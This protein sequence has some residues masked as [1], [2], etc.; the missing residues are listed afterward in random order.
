[1]D[2][3]EK[4]LSEKQTLLKKI[5]VP[6]DI[7][8]DGDE[9]DEIQGA[10]IAGISNTLNQTYVNRINQIEEAISKMNSG[11][12]GVCEECG[13]NISEKRLEFNPCFRHCVVCAEKLEKAAKQRRN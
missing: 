12:Y 7:D 11:E 10:M 4:L 2:F 8:I 13:E 1:M 9:M 6:T 3:K 5:G